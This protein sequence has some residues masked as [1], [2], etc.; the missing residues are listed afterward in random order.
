M[1]PNFRVGSIVG[2]GSALTVASEMVG[3]RPKYVKVSNR[4]SRDCFEWFA[5]MPDDSAIKMVA[6]GTRTAPT[7]NGI[8]PT[9]SGF[10]IGA[11]TDVNVSG[12]TIDY[13][14]IG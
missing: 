2:T 14:A 1:N 4:T 5:D 7:S 3:F 13:L 6:A 12:E 11:D 9:A 8:T 10:T